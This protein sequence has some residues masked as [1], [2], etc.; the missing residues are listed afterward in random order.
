MIRVRRRS[1][2]NRLMAIS[3]LMV[4]LATVFL[5]AG[6]GPKRVIQN[7]PAA[8][9]RVAASPEQAPDLSLPLPRAKGKSGLAPGSKVV[10]ENSQSNKSKVKSTASGGSALGLRAA[11]L[12]K[13][14]LGKKYKWGAEGP[15]RFDCSGLT[16]FVYK[17]VGV[18]L[19][20][21]SRSQSK[22]GKSVSRKELQPGDLL[23]FATSGK[24]VNH[25]GIYVGGSKFIHAPRKYNPVRTDSLNNSWW[26]QRLKVA[27]R[28]G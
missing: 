12:A 10:R 15:D 1:A 17:K 24:T 9:K 23:F 22:F 11:A 13:K 3:V 21:T 25:V 14:Q 28:L 26:R 2:T 19:P 7:D 16:F 8:P 27:R 18:Q 4:L 5:L 20:R 6:C